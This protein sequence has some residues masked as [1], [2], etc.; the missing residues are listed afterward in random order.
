M[1]IDYILN[2]LSP[3]SF[4]SYIVSYASMHVVSYIYLARHSCIVSYTCMHAHVFL[5][6]VLVFSPLLPSLSVPKLVL[7]CL[8]AMSVYVCSYQVS[9]IP[10][11][12][13]TV[14]WTLDSQLFYLRMCTDRKRPN[15]ISFSPH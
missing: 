10:G 11:L 8:L 13:W 1:S 2:I 4:L 3:F 7:L 6:S 14:D 12:D 15:L 5:V 9:T